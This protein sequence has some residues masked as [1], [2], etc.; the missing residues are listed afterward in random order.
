MILKDMLQ[1]L[2]Y[3]VVQGNIDVAVTELVFDSRK[4]VPG[5]VFVALTGSRA[6]GHAYIPQVVEA[7]ASVIVGERPVEVPA[8]VTYLQVENSRVAL[9]ELSAAYFGYPAEQLTVVGITGTKGKTTTS[10]MVKKILEAAGEKAGVIGTN[11]AFIGEERYPTVNTTPES[12]ELQKMFRRMVDVGCKYAVME[13]SSQGIMMHRVDGFSFDYGVFT[14]I[15]PDHIGPDEH[16]DFD[17]Y[18]EYKSQL[19]RRCRVCVVNRDDEHY[20]KI[21]EKATCQVVTFGLEQ[22]ADWTTDRVDYL[23][24]NGFMGIAFHLNGPEN[25]AGSEMGDNGLYVE[26]NIPGLFN[27]Y[28][29]MAAAVLCELMG[30]GQEAICAALKTISVNGRMEIVYASEKFAALVDYAHNAVSMESL[31]TTLRDYNPRRLV[32]IFGCGGNRSKDRRYDMGEIGG[33]MADLSI[34]TADNSRWEKIED[35]MADI[36]IGMDKTDGEFVEIPDRR[37]AIYYSIEHAREGDIIAVI[38][39][40]HEDYQ[41]IRGVRTHFLDREELEAALEKYGYC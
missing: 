6:D 30:I 39:K 31:L 40:G 29:A 14:N 4:A 5:C 13:V 1:R 34:I 21:V 36:R 41:E 17:E 8:H 38:G 28:N 20:E 19:L 11:G 12:Y 18:L 16:K 26:V 15:S 35:I 22:P 3:T 10:T 9:A 25:A 24:K 33:R 32:C 7:G 2:T 23:T 37:E 27:V